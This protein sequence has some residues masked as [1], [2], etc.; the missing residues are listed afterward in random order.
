MKLTLAS[1]LQVVMALLSAILSA[2]QE[3]P[4][5]CLSR[6][7]LPTSEALRYKSVLSEM[8]SLFLGVNHLFS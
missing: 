1:R 3:K 7:L 4:S 6:L 8:Y 2:L 5:L